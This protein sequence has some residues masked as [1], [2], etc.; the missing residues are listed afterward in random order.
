[1]TGK[2]VRATV[3]GTDM[4]VGKPGWLAEEGVDISTGQSD[5]ERLQNRG[6]TVSGVTADGQLVGLVAIGD[7]I[8][9]DAA[10]RSSG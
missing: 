9:E 1:M 3:D 2:G 5:I 4:L 7:T 10:R 8:K 6:T